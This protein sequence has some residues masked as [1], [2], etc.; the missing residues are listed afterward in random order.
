M[1]AY[2]ECS[3]R[4]GG[5]KGNCNRRTVN[6]LRCIES[7]PASGTIPSQFNAKVTC[8]KGGKKVIHTYQQNTGRVT[9]SAGRRVVVDQAAVD[10]AVRTG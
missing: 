7:R 10:A 3:V 8:S 2:Y 6:A 1:L 5:K 9:P 4:A